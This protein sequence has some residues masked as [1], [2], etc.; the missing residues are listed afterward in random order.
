L[1]ELD[2]WLI[3]RLVKGN[4]RGRFPKPG[5][6]NHVLT[7]KLHPEIR[8]LAT[9]ILVQ[10]LRDWLSVAKMSAPAPESF[11][12]LEDSREWLFSEETCPGSFRWVSEIIQIDV[13][14][15]RS[16][17]K[18]YDESNESEKRRIVQKIG[19]ITIPH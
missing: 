13:D 17:L 8:N 14:R 3:N 6:G 11:E 9:A 12:R 19:R 4:L 18:Q 2:S 7:K 5:A 15:L 16:W 10:A 1:N